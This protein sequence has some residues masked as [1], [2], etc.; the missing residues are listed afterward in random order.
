MV[1]FFLF[2]TFVMII[3]IFL[4]FILLNLLLNVFIILWFCNFFFNMYLF[5]VQNDRYFC[6]FHMVVCGHFFYVSKDILGWSGFVMM[7]YRY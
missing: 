6:L 5:D 2:E 3:C 7:K 4:G 1:T